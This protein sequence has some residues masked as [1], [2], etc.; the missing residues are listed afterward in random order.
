[1]YNKSQFS[2]DQKA[3]KQ[4]KKLA[5]PINSTVD[6]TGEG[7]LNPNNQ[8]LDKL[9]LYTDSI[10]N[11]TPYDL[12]L[13]PDNGTPQFKSAWDTST[14]FFPGASEV[15]EVKMKDGGE[16]MDLTDEEIQAYRDGGY[17]V[18]ELPQAQDGNIVENNKLK[19]KI[20]KR[21]PGYINT[22]GDPNNF[23]IVE[24]PNFRARDYGY[25]DIEYIGPNTKE[26]NYTSDYTY[27][28]PFPGEY[29]IP[30][31][32]N[33][34]INKG[35]IFLDMSHGLAS[36]PNVAPYL[37]FFDQ[38]ALQARG[39]DMMWDWEEEKQNPNY[40]KALE[41][42][43]S[44]AFEQFKRN[45]LDGLLRSELSRK[46]M[47]RKT[48]DKGY[49]IERRGNSK[50]MR[51][52]AN[53]IYDYLKGR[54]LPTNQDGGTPIMQNAGTTIN[55]NSDLN[56]S[57]MPQSAFPVTQPFIA[58]QPYTYSGRPGSYYKMIDGKMSIKNKDTDW[59]YVEMK[60][61]TGERL[62]TLEAGLKS[63]STKPYVKPV[64]PK[65]T[66]TINDFY[67][68]KDELT[69]QK[70]QDDAYQC[71]RESGGLCQGSSFLYYDKYI[72]PKLGLDDSW[73]LKEKAGISSGKKGNPNYNLYGES[74]DSWELRAAFGNNVKE[75]YSSGKG[76][77][78]ELY[79]K[80]K[81]M[82]EP[83]KDQYFRD[84][85]LPIGTIIQGGLGGFD[86]GK[87]PGSSYNEQKG[88][89][90]S[91]HTGIVVGYDE[92]G[93]PVIY[94]YGNVRKITHPDNLLMGETFPMN[95]IYVPKQNAKYT[96][97][98]LKKNNKLNEQ[99]KPLELTNFS[100]MAD[101]DEMVPFVEQL[102]KNKKAYMD[103]FNLSN[104][105]YDELARISAATAMAETK[106]G[107]DFGTWRYMLPSYAIDK[108]APFINKMVQ[109]HTAG[110]Y[111]PQAGKSAGITQINP[112]S[113]WSQDQK[114]AWRNPTLVK[115]LS[116]LGI[117][118][119]NYDA[120]NPYH[121]ATVTIGLMN[122]NIPVV[123]NNIKNNSLVKQDLSLAE[124]LYYQWNIPSALTT[125]DPEKAARGDN[126]NVKRFMKYYNMATDWYKRDGGSYNIG[127]EI[128]EFTKNYL[129]GQGYTFEEI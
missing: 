124:A 84:L 63:G 42:E 127:D 89:A 37:E 98:Y 64:E 100:I 26:I 104:D 66:T 83:E 36:D 107:Q 103:A 114:G 128:D 69:K 61:P 10:Y 59:K 79:N 60:D 90:A 15:T 45:Y 2:K 43:G 73:T 87:K 67:F 54:N 119:D 22:F 18:E 8:D 74:A 77:E 51:E 20:F 72:A 71:L 30:Y 111:N 91:H 34:K 25:G 105:E 16:Y 6:L 117:N 118:K 85:N 95:N 102:K 48:T 97:D 57:W 113:V 109:F 52:A 75:F 68:T 12:M 14:T 24:D 86:S 5:R 96:Y 50:E 121:Q 23:H 27:N 53:Y 126:E 120:W 76:N 35:D 46:G 38:A 108:A 129:E 9:S 17:I 3:A 122:S 11:P 13:F 55:L 99:I 88:Y 19:E 116:E 39:D 93:T 41:S 78:Y 33:S 81:N 80:L 82:T 58:N 4:L 49:K 32:P 92:Y 70:L 101:R 44:A 110:L 94:D 21:Y 106:G 1:M 56:P 65:I 29:V 7:F 31:N 123:K 40:I 125:D 115:R 47:G 28:S 112:D 62:K